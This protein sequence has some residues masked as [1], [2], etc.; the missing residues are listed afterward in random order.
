M[1]T[2]DTAVHLQSDY[3]NGK[4]QKTIWKKTFSKQKEINGEKTNVPDI[5]DIYKDHNYK[6]IPPLMNIHNEPNSN[7]LN[8]EP[9]RE[10]EV[11]GFVD[12]SLF[13][14]DDNP[15]VISVKDAELKI[16]NVDEYKKTPTY[17]QLLKN[18]VVEIITNDLERILDKYVKSIQS[19]VS[20]IKNTAND[21]ATRVHINK[22]FRMIYLVIST[23][24]KAFYTTMDLFGELYLNFLN[25][26]TPKDKRLKMD[27]TEYKTLLN[28]AKTQINHIAYFI[29]GMWIVLNWWFNFNYYFTYISFSK[30]LNNIEGVK[31]I[32]ESPLFIFYFFN[33]CFLGL[34]HYDFLNEV[35][36]TLWDWR[37]I[38]FTLL[39][40]TILSIYITKGREIDNQ[41]TSAIG[42]EKNW[43]GNL[44]ILFF[45]ISFLMMDIFNE[46]RWEQR[47]VKYS[48][49]IFVVMF[50][51]IFL[52]FIISLVFS[53]LGVLVLYYYLV[54]YSFFN[55][56][57][58]KGANTINFI[59]IMFLDMMHTVAPPPKVSNEELPTKLWRMFMNMMVPLSLLITIVGILSSNVDIA[60]KM[61]AKHPIK[62]TMY[63][64]SLGV[65]FAFL[66][67]GG[68]MLYNLL[69]K[70]YADIAKTAD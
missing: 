57:V 64:I 7:V 19:I 38:V 2:L 65:L 52:K 15:D 17:K 42:G 39:M 70:N 61:E 14:K 44:N 22:I 10:Q 6:N 28:V 31:I 40:S 25:R 60:F 5:P 53:F 46:L 41:F 50:I 55:L 13:D 24:S 12:T 37:P 3:K 66:F 8:V 59:K 34:K 33:W 4:K 27:S 18:E 58:S 11:E 51:L 68:S 63:W 20:E 43:I 30:H 32:T 62:T 67:G 54:Y 35:K 36:C 48:F 56:L 29:V 69:P 49:L 1:S 26:M 9:H 47:K 16:K 21:I 45:C 23:P